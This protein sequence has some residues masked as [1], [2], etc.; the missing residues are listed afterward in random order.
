[1]DEKPLSLFIFLLTRG[2]YLLSSM[3]GLEWDECT[4]IASALSWYGTSGWFSYI[5]LLNYYN[6]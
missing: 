3:I 6:N 1:M 5:I 4:S 2:L